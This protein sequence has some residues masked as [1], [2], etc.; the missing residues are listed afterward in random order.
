LGSVGNLLEIYA[1]INFGDKFVK[2]NDM[3]IADPAVHTTG[4][5]IAD[6]G[7]ILWGFTADNM[8]STDD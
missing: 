5:S 6:T 4:Y 7:G 3:Y 8:E 1:I 2:E